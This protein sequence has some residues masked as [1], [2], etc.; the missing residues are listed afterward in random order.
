MNARAHTATKPPAITIFGTGGFS[1][2][3]SRTRAFS[4]RRRT[5]L[6]QPATRSAET[7]DAGSSRGSAWWANSVP[8]R[9]Q[10]YSLQM[11][12]LVLLP[13]RV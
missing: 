12:L 2:S 4:R 13:L 5:P 9:T 6:F 3:G 1:S 10:P 11:L 7:A 8:A